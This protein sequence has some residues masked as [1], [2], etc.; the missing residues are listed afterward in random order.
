MPKEKPARRSRMINARIAMIFGALLVTLT[1]AMGAPITE[2]G[3]YLGPEHARMESHSAR[4]G[5]FAAQVR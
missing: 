3:D 2:S 5:F 4:A 1:S